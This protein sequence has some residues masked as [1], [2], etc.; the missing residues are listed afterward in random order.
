MKTVTKRVKR[1]MD[2][3]VAD[4]C[5]SS[6]KAAR[7]KGLDIGGW[8]A[9][10]V[11]VGLDNVAARLEQETSSV[12]IDGS[13][14][15][16]SEGSAPARTADA[17]SVQVTEDVQSRRST[18]SGGVCRENMVEVTIVAPG[19]SG[20]GPATVTNAV[21]VAAPEQVGDEVMMKVKKLMEKLKKGSFGLQGD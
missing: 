7:L 9:E 12:V 18:G 17:W 1:K 6:N 19:L 11:P 4:R 13:V 3:L 10:G 14:A 15:L 21:A 16:S 2:V 8:P 5:R 20:Q